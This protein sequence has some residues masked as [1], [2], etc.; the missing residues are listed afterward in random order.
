MKIKNYFYLIFFILIVSFLFLFSI[1]NLNKEIFDNNFNKDYGDSIIPK[2]FFQIWINNENKIPNLIEEN[3]KNI[4]NEN[5]DFECKLYNKED[6]I[7]FLQNNYHEDI[8]KTYNKIIPGAYK[9]DL[10]RYCILY[11]TGG[12]YLDAKMMPI[13]N[14]KL[15]DVTNKEYF[16]RDFE[17]SQKGVW[18][19]FIVCKKNNPIL[20]DAINSIV[21]N[22]KNK[23]Y[24]E[25]CLSPTGPLLLK[26]MFTDNEINN[27]EY[28]YTTSNNEPDLL[29]VSKKPFNYDLAIL[30]KDNKIYHEQSLNRSENNYVELWSEKKIYEPFQNIFNSKFSLL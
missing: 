30:K 20:L 26:K 23:Y 7:E 3:F 18:N 1:K 13:N 10:M 21:E 9:A 22:V 24:G 15:K 6:C 27:F 17:S 11:K 5:P 19:G 29:I 28:E 12:I 14:F 8:I 16:I 4:K 2:Y 25:S